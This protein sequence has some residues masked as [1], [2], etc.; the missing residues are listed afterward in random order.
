[1]V[2]QSLVVELNEMLY[3]RAIII[4]AIVLVLLIIGMNKLYD[5]ETFISRNMTDPSY[6]ET[7]K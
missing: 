4:V 3:G 2:E 5:F 1:M 7:D 6:I